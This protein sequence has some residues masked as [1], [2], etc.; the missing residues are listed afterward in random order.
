MWIDRDE[1]DDKVLSTLGA[2]L[3]YQATRRMLTLT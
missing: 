3:V 1:L 2:A